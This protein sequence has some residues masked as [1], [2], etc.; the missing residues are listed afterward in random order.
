MMNITWKVHAS[1]I[2]RPK[3]NTYN[4]ALETVAFCSDAHFRTESQ[5]HIGMQSMAMQSMNSCTL[6]GRP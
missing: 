4:L 3:V 1:Q 6:I 2:S 5:P